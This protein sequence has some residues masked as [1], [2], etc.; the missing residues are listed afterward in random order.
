MRFHR[1][2]IGIIVLFLGP[3]AA[4]GQG[5][6]WERQVET[7][8]TQ[9]G[10][11]LL[12]NGYAPMTTTWRGALNNSE[13]ASDTITLAG[14]GSYVLLGVCDDDCGEIELQLFAANGY[15]ID[16]SKG[17]GAAPIVHVTPPERTSYRLTIRMTGCGM[18]PCWYGVSMYRRGEH[19]P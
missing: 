15:E 16:A 6:R 7:R 3:A 17:A 8:F 9:A 1:S 12:R 18:N 19:R 10:V 4:M 11:T 5:N 2:A 14:G 13:T